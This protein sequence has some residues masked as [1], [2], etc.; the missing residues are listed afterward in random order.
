MNRALEEAK[1]GGLHWRVFLLSAMG[2]FL[3]GFDLFI[4][5]IALPLIVREFVP[6]PFEIGLIGSAALLGSV[7]GS[8]VG[9]QV[10]RSLRKKILIH[11]RYDIFCSVRHPLS[12]FMGSLVSDRFQIFIGYG[13]RRR[14][15]DM[16]VLCFRVY[17][18][19]DKGKNVNKRI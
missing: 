5:G 13:R 18:H 12:I 7:L 6:G 19:K 17:A 3:D 14:L 2:V 16:R 4:I 8:F 11:C 10:Y 15:S 1:L 9:G